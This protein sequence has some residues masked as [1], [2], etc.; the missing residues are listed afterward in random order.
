M[1]AL[2]L[3]DLNIAQS[4]KAHSV[5]V[6]EFGDGTVAWLAEL[7]SDER[8]ARLEVG[9]MEYQKQRGNE[10]QIGFRA[11]AVAACLCSGADR[12][13][14]AQ[15]SSDIIAAAMQLGPCSGKPVTR[16]FAKLQ[17]VNGLG[18]EQAEA[19]EKN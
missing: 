2:T 11:W 12:K 19:L 17:E 1:P 5:P 13:F 16:M 3:Q 18:A 8:D 15:C 7:T 4:L 10:S 6:P 14:L 9:W